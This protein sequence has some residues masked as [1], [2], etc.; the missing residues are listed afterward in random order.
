MPRERERENFKTYLGFK[1]YIF[2]LEFR[3]ELDHLFLGLG[4]IELGYRD[5]SIAQ[6]GVADILMDIQ[7][8]DLLL[9]LDA[10]GG[11]GCQQL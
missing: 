5:A 3:G 2:G 10:I 1:Y 6:Q 8:A 11:G 9:A 7:V 4:N